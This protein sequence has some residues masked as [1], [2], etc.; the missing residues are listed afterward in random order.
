[1]F[2]DFR[3]DV[4]L[5]FENAMKYNEEQTVV[6]DMA[7]VLKKKFDL[8]YNKMLM[9]LDEDHAENSSGEVS[10]PLLVPGEVPVQLQIARIVAV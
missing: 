1:S 10:V 2:E 5:T 6:H 7:K 8:D 4:Q 9:S 3:A